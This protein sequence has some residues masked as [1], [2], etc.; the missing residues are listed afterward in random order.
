MSQAKKVD[1]RIHDWIDGKYKVERVLGHSRHDSKFKVVDRQGNQYMLKLLNLWQVDTARQARDGVRTESEIASCSIPSNYLT[2]IVGSGLASGNPYLLTR[3]YTSV[4]LTKLHRKGN[5]G[6]IIANVLFGLKDLHQNGK[7]HSNLTAE[8]VLL[9][10]DNKVLLTN[11]VVLGNRN[12][13]VIDYRHGGRQ[14]NL[15]LVYAAP[16]RFNLEKS[17]TILPTA[18][19]YSVGVL[20]YYLLTGRYPYGIVS[21]METY[22]AKSNS[23]VW[24]RTFLGRENMKWEEFLNKALSTDVNVRPQSVEE[25]LALMPELEDIE[26]QQPTGFKEIN[27]NPQ[28]GILLRLMQGEEFG[29]IY[30]LG[31]LFANG[32]KRILTLGRQDSSVFNNI[33]IPESGSTYVSRRHSTIELD[34]ETG[35]VYIRDGQWD[36]NAT[37][38]WISS[39]NG[40]FVNSREIS[41]EGAEITPGD[42]ISIGDVKLRVEGY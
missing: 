31:E 8:N 13:F 30:R 5:I 34:N 40:T 11:Y 24:N 4:D 38:G 26:Y 18:D 33:Q 10:D 2:E 12:Q 21:N 7:V 6:Q 27:R 32:S 29:K 3:Y 35:K 17:A 20:A 22:L 16:E 15:T 9:T 42:I 23:G 19:I 39:L 36:K 25:A 37:D 1:F 41:N 28:N 14:S